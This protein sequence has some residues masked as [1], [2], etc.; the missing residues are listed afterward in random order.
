MA[1]IL[2]FLPTYNEKENLEKLIETILEIPL[3]IKVLVVDDQSPDGTGD[4]AQKLSDKLSEEKVSVIHRPPPRGRGRAGIDGFRIGSESE[5]KYIIEMD[6]DFSHQPQDIPRLI[7]AME[8]S[9]VVLGSRY[10]KGGKIK[11]WGLYRVINSAVANLLSRVILGLK[12]KDCTSG[13]RCFKREVLASLDWDKMISVGPSIVEE[14]LYKVVKQKKWKISEI[15]ITF[16]DRTEGTSK[17]GI[18]LILKWIQNL[19]QVRF[20]SNA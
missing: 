20:Q 1:D 15:P 8:Q 6:A 5:C 13:F 14:I 18:L 11:G 4:I 2:I 16:I 19:I 12:T 9:D 10:V 17:V 3:S 7:E